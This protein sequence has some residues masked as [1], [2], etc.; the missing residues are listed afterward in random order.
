[1]QG[2]SPG[3]INNLLVQLTGAGV[4][5]E[6]RAPKLQA[7]EWLAM[8][9]QRHQAIG[10][11]NIQTGRELPIIGQPPLCLPIIN[12]KNQSFDLPNCGI[13]IIRIIVSLLFLFFSLQWRRLQVNSFLL[14][15]S[16]RDGNRNVLQILPPPPV[17]LPGFAPQNLKI[18][19]LG[20]NLNKS[21]L[22]YFCSL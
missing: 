15:S 21:P 4:V 12:D 13:S 3:W 2:W 18:L 17:L 19:M 14:C 9:L 10:A 22:K 5:L 6:Y 11:P 7:M 8:T 1:M 20:L 16:S